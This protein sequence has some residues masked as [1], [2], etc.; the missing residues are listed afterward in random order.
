MPVR[1]P[2]SLAKVRLARL[3]FGL[4]WVGCMMVVLTGPG[5]RFGYLDIVSVQT[6]FGLAASA[7]LAAIIGGLA[8]TLLLPA[9]DSRVNWLA[10][11]LA[12]LYRVV[13]SCV[14]GV[15][16]AFLAI[17][18]VPGLGARTDPEQLLILAGLGIAIA[19]PLGFI[20]AAAQPTS[21]ARP[22]L[23]S[24][25]LGIIMGV[26][27]AYI[28]IT[29]RIA[30][31]S[32]PRINDVSTDIERP[33]SFV[34]LA[35]KPA[36]AGNGGDLPDPSTAAAQRTGYPDIRPLSLKL[37]P[38][39][40]FA[41]LEQAALDMGW[42]IVARDPA[43]G[44]LEAVSTTL[45]FGFKDDIVVRVAAAGDGCRID[46]RS[47]SRVGISDLGANAQRIRLFLARVKK[48]A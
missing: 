38:D 33:P 10:T 15:I 44:R 8:L 18:I 19:V 2:P 28:P 40:A 25:L 31:D 26:A 24:S 42:E 36:V 39:V 46:V 35:R 13:V 29:W 21:A 22:G 23:L 30:A 47:R 45:W 34:T 14:F 27:A 7:A 9:H 12:W 48:V 5:Y 16:L 11:G 43:Q 37:P 1:R 32:L 3:V 17:R 20:W 6:S 41:R 4:G